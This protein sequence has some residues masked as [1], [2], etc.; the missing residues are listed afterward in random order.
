MLKGVSTRTAGQA[1]AP[2][3]AC[4]GTG[5]GA[6]LHNTSHGEQHG[7]LLLLL[8]MCHPLKHVKLYFLWEGFGVQAFGHRDTL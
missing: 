7:C 8:P 2:H 3:V 4:S 6:T 5:V 1:E